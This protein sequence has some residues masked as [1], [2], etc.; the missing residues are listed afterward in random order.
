[1]GKSLKLIIAIV[2]AWWLGGPAI[3]AAARPAVNIGFQAMTVTDAAGVPVEIGV[4][5]PTD[6]AATP[7]ALAGWSQIVAE[8]APAA[9]ET[10]ADSASS[11]SDKASAPPC[12]T[13]ARAAAIRVWRR[14]PW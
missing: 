4:W 5:Y 6:V 8:G 10:P 13:T 1:M 11:R 12:S 2:V 3:A 9:R 14:S 7:H